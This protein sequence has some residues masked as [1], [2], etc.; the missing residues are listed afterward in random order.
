MSFILLQGQTVSA[1]SIIGLAGKM[2]K[3]KT[4]PR[5]PAPTTT[6]VPKPINKP[7]SAT[8]KQMQ[9]DQTSSLNKM[10][11]QEEAGKTP[12]KTLGFPDFKAMGNKVLEKFR[13][14]DLKMGAIV[15]FL[16]ELGLDESKIKMVQV[17]KRI[18]ELIDSKPCFNPNQLTD[19]QLRTELADR[20]LQTTGNRKQ[21][22]QRI[23]QADQSKCPHDHSLLWI[24]G[25]STFFQWGSRFVRFP[26][27]FI[28]RPSGVVLT[29]VP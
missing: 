21:M 5:K 22:V 9:S 8:Q 12:Q 25:I 3:D 19:D 28:N 24:C 2:K 1:G 10:K 14:R 4:P 23:V 7:V 27:F 29:Q 26:L 20:K 6:M 18:K 11:T 15:S 13:L 16:D 17:I